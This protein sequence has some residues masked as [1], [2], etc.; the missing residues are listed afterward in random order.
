VATNSD[1]QYSVQFFSLTNVVAFTN[2][3]YQL[4]NSPYRTVTIEH[5]GGDTNHVRV[6]DSIDGS[7]HDYT[8]QTNGWLLV[9]GGGLRSELKTNVYSETNTVR[10]VTT[11]ISDG[12][13]L[14][15]QDQHLFLHGQWLSTA[16][17][18]GGWFLGIS[19]L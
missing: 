19:P 5:V 7:V 17:R 4:A 12:V 6:T 8:W 13:N 11:T 2:G 18:P 3:G 9:T 15:C 14:G 10:T 16:N 1:T